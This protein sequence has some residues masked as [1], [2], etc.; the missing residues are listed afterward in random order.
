MVSSFGATEYA[1]AGA[2]MAYGTDFAAVYR[3]AARLVD[4]ILKGTAPAVIPVEQANVYELV[5]N[6]RTAKTLGISVPRSILLQ[7][8]RVIE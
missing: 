1:D 8:T 2:F 6:L 3:Q 5:I 7:A 4:R